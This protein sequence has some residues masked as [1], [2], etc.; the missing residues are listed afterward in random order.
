MSNLTFV[1][2]I[3]FQVILVS[4]LISI[5]LSFIYAFENYRPVKT[6]IEVIYQ[7]EQVKDISNINFRRNNEYKYII[8]NVIN[9]FIEKNEIKKS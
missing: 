4:L 5:F 8:Y 3:S 1:K 6:L 7:H 2:R 9:N